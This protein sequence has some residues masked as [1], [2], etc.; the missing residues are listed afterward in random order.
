MQGKKEENLSTKTKNTVTRCEEN[1]DVKGGWLLERTIAT[2][3]FS[4]IP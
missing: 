1:M 4:L 3:P 2:L